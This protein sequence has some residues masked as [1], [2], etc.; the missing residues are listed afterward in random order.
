MAARETGQ[1]LT[2]RQVFGAMLRYYRDRAGL[3]R[4]QLAR[5]AHKSESLIAA[6]ERGERVATEQVAEDLDAVTELR[7]EGSLCELRGKLKEGLNY[8]PFPA[9]FHEWPRHEATAV[10]LRGFE[11]CI[12]P[13]L[14]QTDMY[15]RAVLRTR[16]GVTEE[17]LDEEVAA[18]LK[19]QEILERDKP[20]ALWMILD[21]QVLRRPV[22]GR[23]LQ[24][25]QMSRLVDSARL[26]NI[27]LQVIPLD[28]GSHEGLRGAGFAIAD[29]PDGPSV[30]YQDTA[31]RG[32]LVEDPE[33]VSALAVSWDTLRGQALPEGA[34]LSLLE[35]AAKSWSTAV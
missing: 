3:S 28:T 1:T 19:R 29:P 11:P 10:R 30:A 15:A 6:I 25:E 26:P 9:W 16:M 12:V 14:L 31:V 8:Q 33:D 32:Q 27:S 21:E 24:A 18:R 22:G 23:H 4:M 13:G 34:S 20:P 7:T 17:E 5:L 2:P 35:E